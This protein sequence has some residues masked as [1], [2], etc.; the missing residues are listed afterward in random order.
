MELRK[1]RL[2]TGLTQIQAAQAVG[3]SKSKI[4]KQEKAKIGIYPED[5]HKLLDLYRVTDQR[6]VEI[7]DLARSAQEDRGWSYVRGGKKLPQDW[8]TWIEFESN[9]VAL[10]NY[11][12]L[13]IPGLLQTLEY[14]RAVIQATAPDISDSEPGSTDCISAIVPW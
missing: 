11:E 14:A 8:Q 7:F 13:L 2:A 6:R 1:L 10:F 3:M 12:T 4:G 9:A 5:L